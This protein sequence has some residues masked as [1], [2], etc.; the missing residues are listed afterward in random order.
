MDG[1]WHEGGG[2]AHCGIVFDRF[3]EVHVCKRCGMQLPHYATMD[4]YV[5]PL[6]WSAIPSER[7]L[8]QAAE[9]KSSTPTKSKQLR[10]EGNKRK[11]GRKRKRNNA[12]ST[13]ARDTLER[14]CDVHHVPKYVEE[15]TKELLQNATYANL[16][17]KSH[18]ADIAFC[19]HA[20]QKAFSICDSPKSALIIANW[21]HISPSKIWK[22]DAR[23]DS[24]PAEEH[25]G[26]ARAVMPSDCVEHARVRL[27]LPFAL[28]RVIGE[29]AD[30]EYSKHACSPR[31]FLAVC[32]YNY[33]N[34]RESFDA[35]L[36]L[37]NKKR[38]SLRQCARSCLVSPTSVSRLWRK[39]RA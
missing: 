20:L 21:F 32:M 4:A 29:K 12:V 8:K 31:T 17:I 9:Q 1:C 26:S 3:N 14:V 30:A 5:R 22:I 36:P 33:L 6:T 19:A 13:F 38:F 34:A 28:A 27:R 35:L 23:F 11:G 37:A 18:G 24:A 16:L 39:L 25:L 15:R 10:W 7:S 2:G